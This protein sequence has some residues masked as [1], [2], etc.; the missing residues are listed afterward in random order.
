MI[1]IN[2]NEGST[3]EL[4]EGKIIIESNPNTQIGLSY[5]HIEKE[6]NGDDFQFN[7]QF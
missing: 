3:L 1:V 2:T 6:E 7:G 5:C 4:K